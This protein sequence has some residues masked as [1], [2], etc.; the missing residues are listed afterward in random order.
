M[1]RSKSV[2]NRGRKIPTT[3]RSKVQSVELT[4]SDPGSRRT[5]DAG[6]RCADHLQKGTVCKINFKLLHK[7]FA[8]GANTSAANS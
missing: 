8:H 1:K 4:A 3:R 5:R 6:T 2:Q 7:N